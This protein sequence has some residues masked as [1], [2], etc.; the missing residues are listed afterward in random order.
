M[1]VFIDTGAFL[2]RYLARDEH[3]KNALAAW[4]ELAGARLFTS[5]HVLDETATLLGRR[6]GHSFAADRLE[7]IYASQAIEIL[8]GTRADELEALRWFRKFCDQKVSF[9]DCLSFALMKRLGIPS[10]FTFDQH[11]TQAGFQTV[12]LR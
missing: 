9:T 1:I 11:F 6:A 10:A 7:N 2:A 3:H 4:K 8:Y 5:N 12:E